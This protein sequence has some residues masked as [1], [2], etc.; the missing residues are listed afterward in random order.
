MAD[1]MHVCAIMIDD[2]WGCVVT[3]TFI[4]PITVEDLPLPSSS[5]RSRP[6]DRLALVGRKVNY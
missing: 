6:F 3:T 1:R 5:R 4:A 2:E